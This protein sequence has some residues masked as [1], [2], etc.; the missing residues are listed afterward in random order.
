MLQGLVQSE[1][2]TPADSGITKRLVRKEI[3]EKQGDRYDFQVPLIQK[4]VEYLVE[5]EI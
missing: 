2:S 3:L 5:E 1:A 4:Y